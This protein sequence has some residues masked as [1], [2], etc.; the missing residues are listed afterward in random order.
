MQTVLL[1]QD[2]VMVIR[3]VPVDKSMKGF[4]LQVP[5]HVCYSCCSSR[6]C[7][8]PAE[9]GRQGFGLNLGLELSS[10]YGVA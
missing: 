10:K 9:V 2:L 3:T 7:I 5:R 6:D 1:S 8:L 4:T